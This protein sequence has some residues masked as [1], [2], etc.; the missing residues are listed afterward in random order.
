MKLLTRKVCASLVGLLVVGPVYAQSVI[1]EVTVRAHKVERAL[2][3]IPAAVGVVTIEDIQTGRQQLGLDE[4]LS[5][6]PGVFCA[7]PIQLCSGS[8]CGDSR[9]WCA[10][11]FRNP[12][13]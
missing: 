13:A 10:G 12:R 8:A 4:S 3:D 6:I 1:E 5:R 7:E 9:L 2:M 11:E